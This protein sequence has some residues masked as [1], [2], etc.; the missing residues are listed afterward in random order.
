MIAALVFAFIAPLSTSRADPTPAPATPTNTPATSSATSPPANPALSAVP[1]ARVAKRVVIIPISGELDRDGYAAS[2]V[3]RRIKTA[4]RAGADA[5]VFELDVS[6][7]IGGSTVLAQA[8][9]E[10][11]V[12]RTVAW[13][14]PQAFGGGTL[15]ALSSKDIILS[16]TAQLGKGMPVTPSGNV[17]GWNNA[18]QAYQSL[19][20][21]IISEAV[22]SARA[23]NLAANEYVRDEDLTRAFVAHDIDLWLIRE[24]ATGKLMCAKLSEMQDLFPGQTFTDSGRI[25]QGPSI[26]DLTSAANQKSQL[27]ISASISTPSLRPVLDSTQAGKWELVQKVPQPVQVP[28][29]TGKGPPKFS[30]VLGGADLVTFGLASNPIDPAT[31]ALVPIRTQDDITAYFQAQHVR[32]MEPSWAEGLLI[33]LTHRWVRALL[34]VIFLIALFAEMSHPG[35]SIPGIVALVALGLFAAPSMI[36]GMTQWWEIGVILIGV[37]LIAVEIFLIPGFGVPGILGLICLFIGLVATFIPQGALFPDSPRQQQD[38]LYALSTVMLAMVTAGFGMFFIARHLP[39]IPFMQHLVLRTG[40]IE[41]ADPLL[42]A[43]DTRDDLPVAPGDSGITLTPM[44]PAGRIQVGDHVLDAVCEIGFIDSGVPIRV[45][46][47]TAMRISVESVA[48]R[49]A[50]NSPASS[51]E[52]SA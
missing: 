52:P 28:S 18:S 19:V 12:P 9:R 5:I 43:M 44:R 39:S 48:S 29:A 8:I 6:G 3:R 2:S 7:G 10:C 1:A 49:S 50:G 42:S 17:R 46:S 16:D 20:I 51:P 40:D 32:V 35:A 15:V 38:L 34:I 11:P 4:V 23:I 26:D 21:G 14:H 24:K 41:S 45:V 25:Q 37:V 36:I 31:G 47:A 13:I 22:A 27:G 33:F 30:L